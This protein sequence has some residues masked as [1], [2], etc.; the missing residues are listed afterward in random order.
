MSVQL[1]AALRFTGK[2]IKMFC[3]F[4]DFQAESLPVL[5]QADVEEG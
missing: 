5:S 4:Q 3:Y 2:S 1:I